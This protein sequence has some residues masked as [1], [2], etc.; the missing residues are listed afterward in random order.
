[1]SPER[2]A[3]GISVMGWGFKAGLLGREPQRYRRIGHHRPPRG[4]SAVWQTLPLL[5]DSEAAKGTPIV[6]PLTNM[7]GGAARGLNLN[8]VGP[9][10]TTT[11]PPE[12]QAMLEHVRAIYSDGV[13]HPI[14]SCAVPENSEVELTIQTVGTKPLAPGVEPPIITDPAER[15]ERLKRLT[16]RMKNNPIPA[17][18]PKFTREQLHERR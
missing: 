9:T 10:I 2:R 11:P 13:F 12:A 1:M 3:L 16:D 4:V 14:S 5:S 15:R 8:I 18:A 7:S 17:D 6:A